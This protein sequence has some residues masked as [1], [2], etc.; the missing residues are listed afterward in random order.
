MRVI[1]SSAL[2]RYFSKEEGWE[3]VEQYVLDSVTVTLA[4][5]EVGNSLRKKV[6]KQEIQQKIANEILVKYAK[7]VLLL[8][9][10]EYVN[11]AFQTSS[12]NDINFYDSMFIAACMEESFELVTCD[13]NQARVARNLGIGVIELT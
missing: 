5:S 8:H 1:D 4:I 12:L 10:E 2:V 3:R 11:T 9:D 6:L 13:G 7:K